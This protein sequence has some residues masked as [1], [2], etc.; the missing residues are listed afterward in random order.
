MA[1]ESARS[2]PSPAFPTRSAALVLAV[3][4]LV[5]LTYFGL[6]PSSVTQPRYVLYP[7]LWMNVALYAVWRVSPADPPDWARH[8][9]DFAGVGYFLALAF[10]GGLLAV[11][12]PEHAHSHLHG[13]RVTMAS[14]GYGPR[15]GYVGEWFHVYVVPYRVVGYA[16]LAYLLSA[17]IRDASVGSL[18]AVSGVLGVVTCIGCAFPL[19]ASVAS[20]GGLLAGIA[21]AATAYPLD[22]STAAFLVAVAALSWRPGGA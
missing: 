16:A 8:L 2:L 9:A 5:L 4:A 13:L 21:A 22:V 20:G 19:L 18:R 12:G 7:F 3:E 6:T 17:A 14:P 11:F 15:V 1:T 10:L